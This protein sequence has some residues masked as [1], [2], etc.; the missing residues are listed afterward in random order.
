MDVQRQEDGRWHFALGPVEKWIVAVIAVGLLAGLG[1]GFSYTVT[2]MQKLVVGQALESQQLLQMQVTLAG[3][4][5]L[6]QQVVELDVKVARDTSDIAN[7]AHDIHEL[8]QV[9]GHL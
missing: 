6:Q 2:T 7:N 1:T 4:P 8:Q 9:R 3:V 5:N